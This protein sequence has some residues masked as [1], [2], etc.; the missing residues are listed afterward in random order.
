MINGA[1]FCYGLEDTVREVKDQPVEKWKIWGKTAIPSG[2]YQL[3]IN[4]SNRFKRQMTQIMNVPGFS[5]VRIHNGKGPES[6]DGCLIVGKEELFNY[7]RTAMIELEN[8]VMNAL[9]MKEKITIEF[10]NGDDYGRE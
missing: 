7:D 5:G 8:K 4:W 10:I 3:V 2:K 9:V 1:F 6:T